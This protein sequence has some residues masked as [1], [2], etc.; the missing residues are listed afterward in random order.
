MAKLRVWT[1]KGGEKKLSMK[2]TPKAD[3]P[4][5]ELG[6]TTAVGVGT[7]KAAFFDAA[8]GKQVGSVD[9]DKPWLDKPAFAR[10][11]AMMA[12]APKG[13]Y[14]ALVSV[15]PKLP[16]QGSSDPREDAFHQSESRDRIDCEMVMGECASQYI[17]TVYS[18]APSPTKMWQEPIEK[19]TSLTFDRSGGRLLI[20]TDDGAIHVFAADG[21]GQAHTEKF[22]RGPIVRIASAP[23]D[24]WA[25]SE[26]AAGQ[27]RVWSLP[28]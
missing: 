1:S 11:F 15:G 14:V 16:P 26:D 18:L 7:K 4:G 5:W 6:G 9:V 17:V 24:H 8:S 28:Q 27:Q 21:K 19:P 10:S 22:H 2:C 12:V 13:N 23:A 3:D 25:M 20:G